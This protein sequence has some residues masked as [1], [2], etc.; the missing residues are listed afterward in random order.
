[1]PPRSFVHLHNH[2]QFSLLDGAQKIEEMVDQAVAF[3][4]PAVAITDHGN[5]FGAIRFVEKCKEKGIKPILGCEA[6][7]APGSRLDRTSSREGE[8]PYHHLIL[9]VENRKGYANL[10]KLVTKAY[11]DGFYYKPRIDK[12]LLAEHAE[13]L[14]GTSACLGGEVASRLLRDDAAGAEKAAAAYRDIFGAGNFFLEVQD[15]GIPEEKKVNDG[16]AEIARRLEIP[17]VGT[18]DCHFLR[19]DD[20]FSHQVLVCIQTGKTVN[21]PERLKYTQEHYFKSPEEMLAVFGDLPE[22]V[23]NTL[24]IAERCDFDLGLSE[25]HLPRFA[26]PEG[27]TVEGYFEKVVRQGF[28]RRGVQWEALLSRD[29]LRHPLDAYRQRLESEIGMVKSMGFPGYFLIVWDFIRY[30]RERGIAVG[31]GRGS[32]AGSLVAYCLGITDI[33]P[34]QY[35]LL[36]ERFLNPERVSLPDIDIDFCMRRRGE[37]IDYVRNKYGQENV[38][39]IIT[40]GTMAARAVIRDAGRGLDIPYGDVDRIAKLVP[41]E[42]DATVDKALASVP[43]LKSAY[44]TD[45]KIRRLLDVA[46]RLE[47]LARHAS[48]HAAGVVISPSPIVEFAPL[49]A[50]KDNEIITQYAKDEIEKIGLLKMDFLGLKTLTLLEDCVARVQN[51][52]GVTLTLEA[53]P[54]SDR[55]T[56]A[57]FCRAQTSGVFQFESSGMQDILRKLQPDR[58]EDL[59]ALNALYRPGPIKSGMIEEYIRG[60]HGKANVQAMPRLREILDETYG[61]I[62]YQEQVMRIASVLGGFTLGQADLLRRAMGK[63]KQKEMDAMRPLFLKGAR[64]RGIPEKEA[65]KIFELMAQFAGYG[66]NKSHSAAYAL[67]AYQTAYLKAHFPVQFMAA[68]LT[69]E[70]E[71]TDNV[72]KYIA[73]CREMGIAVH[74]PDINRSGLD[75]T[76]EE[77]ALRFGLGAIKNVGDGTIEAILQARDRVGSF[78]SLAGLCREVDSRSMNRKALESLIKSGALDGFGAARQQLMRSLDA[79][80]ASAHKEVRDQQAGQASLFGGEAPAGETVPSFAPQGDDWSPRELLSFEKETLGFYLSGHPLLEHGATL[81]ALRG[82]TTRSLAPEASGRTV[83]MGGLIT[84]LKKRKT[85]RGDWMAV[86]DLEDLEGSIEAIVFPELYKTC[87]NRLENDVAVLVKGKAEME[88][89]RWRLVAEEISALAGAAERQA[90]RVVLRVNASGLQTERV[91]Q[92]HRLLQDHPG[93]CPVEILLTQPGDYR[94]TLLP[95]PRLRVGPNPSLTAALEQVLGKGAVVFR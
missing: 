57:L 13:G 8:K 70:K 76:V 32:A 20:H 75:F 30:A 86:F 29:A 91:L 74:P 69:V 62:V 84:S 90:S 10:L 50:T 93:E 51:G 59:I 24:R 78:A 61:V 72:V 88:E 19:R 85:K 35:G 48:T 45:E 33:D 6:Y 3:K 26:V 31:P 42:L 17:R 39:Q 95:D 82:V 94:L 15:Q 60:R 2:S 46:R 52:P 79:C 65:Q 18:N 67:I 14:I 22:A 40:F 16:L 7:I 25:N 55:E 87:Q 77:S 49:C 68:L 83:R 21:D 54:L 36:F 81:E 66:F 80:V 9:L 63:K 64:E 5:L 71:V 4:M 89:G 44:E 1:M 73:Q 34:L 11:L 43:Q 47:G 23:E 27:E 28:E 56:Y 37:V 58:F 53:L 38:A 41:P 92:I 12:E